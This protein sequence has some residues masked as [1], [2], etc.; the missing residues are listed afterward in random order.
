[1]CHLS[2]ILKACLQTHFQY[3]EKKI[4]LFSIQTQARLT[5]SADIVSGNRKQQTVTNLTVFFH[6]LIRCSGGPYA[7]AK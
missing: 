1:M 4:A 3:I 2:N 5:D 6:S 7:P